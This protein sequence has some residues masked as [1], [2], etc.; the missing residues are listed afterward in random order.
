MRFDIPAPRKGIEPA[1]SKN[2]DT[3]ETETPTMCLEALISK[4]R[5]VEGLETQSHESRIK[6]EPTPCHYPFSP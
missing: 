1:S 3:A 2:V 4:I 6:I 5:E